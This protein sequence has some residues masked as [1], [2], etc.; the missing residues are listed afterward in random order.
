MLK[1]A[2]SNKHSVYHVM[3]INHV[4]CLMVSDAACENMQATIRMHFVC[5]WHC[6][7]ITMQQWMLG[8]KLSAFKSIFFCDICGSMAEHH[9]GKGVGTTD[10]IVRP[11]HC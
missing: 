3:Y 2:G 1:V 7:L 5:K 9:W 11:L 10:N 4:E 8:D 6:F